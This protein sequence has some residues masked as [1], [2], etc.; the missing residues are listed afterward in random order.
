MP[1]DHHRNRFAQRAVGQLLLGI[2]EFCI[3]AL[4]IADGELD[5]VALCNG[6]QFIGFVKFKRDRLF[7]QHMLAGLQA[8]ARDRIMRVLRRGRDIDDLHRIILDDVLVI[9]CRDSGIGELLDFLQPVRA[10]V[11][12]MQ[13]FSPADSARVFRRESP[14]PSGADDSDFDRFY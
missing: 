1:A 9:R 13:L 3:E 7:Q 5:V 4:R 8:I 11:A 10:D 12:D 14:A 2:G 6:D